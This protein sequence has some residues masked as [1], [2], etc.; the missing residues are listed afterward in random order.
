MAVAVVVDSDVETE[1]VKTVKAI[2]TQEVMAM[3]LEDHAYQ[4][5]HHE[6]LMES[7]SQPMK[8]TN[9]FTITYILHTY[10]FFFVF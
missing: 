4:P 5:D 10:I 1:N 3:D 9:A 7:E 2:I 8:S 6:L